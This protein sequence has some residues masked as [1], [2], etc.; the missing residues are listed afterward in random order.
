[1]L[2]H[3]PVIGVA[4]GSIVL[5][6]GVVRRSDD[7]KIVGL[8]AL[9]LSALVAVP[10]YLTGEP[11]EEVVE[12]MPGV[13]E[14]I[15]GL[16]EDSATVSLI[17]AMIAGLFALVSLTTR[18]L[19]STTVAKF[20]LTGTLVASLATGLLMARTANLGGQI[21]HSEIRGTTQTTE[22]PATDQKRRSDDDD[23]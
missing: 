6:W 16:H 4:F 14:A 21:R 3:L 11:A 8:I 20:A 2:N 15:I 18:W 13:S 7:V 9:V 22:P 5:I 1:M 23:H 10:V 19:R 17:F 12:R